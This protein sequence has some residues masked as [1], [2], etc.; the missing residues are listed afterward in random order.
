[1]RPVRLVP[2]VLSYSNA[3]VVCGSRRIVWVAMGASFAVFVDVFVDVFVA[4]LVE[5]LVEVF[6]VVS[7]GVASA[8]GQATTSVSRCCHQPSSASRSACMPYAC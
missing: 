7:V 3:A 5:V 1:M 4:V 2:G 8:A 6:V